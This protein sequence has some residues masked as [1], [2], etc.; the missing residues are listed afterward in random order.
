MRF[1]DRAVAFVDILGFKTLVDG[2]A[3][4]DK[5]LSQ[6]SGL[7]KLLSSAVPMLNESVDS[8]IGN[9][10]IPKHIYISDCIILSAPL[11]DPNT[12]S[13]DGLSIVV[14]RV[15]QLSHY[16]L[17]AGYLIR[18]GISVGKV[19]HT[20]S[21][22][23]GPAYQEAYCLEKKGNEPIVALAELAAKQWRGGSRMCLQHEGKV[24][25]NGLFD[26]Y[27]PNSNKHGEIEQSYNRYASLVDQRLSEELPLSARM[28][29][30][31]FNK[32]LQSEVSEGLKWTQA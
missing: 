31:W 32:F 28:K 8:S 27:I 29:W 6:L 16:F 10:L 1:Q 5:Q 23:V 19:W 4:N 9:H 2:A 17:N 20:D 30:C 24:F 26:Y 22:I 21:N 7:I 13:Y 14:M 25:V 18:G 12:P 3:K 11:I 15:I